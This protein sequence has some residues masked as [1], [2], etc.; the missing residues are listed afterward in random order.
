MSGPH[1][2]PPPP[3]VGEGMYRI[4]GFAGSV[5]LLPP[6]ELGEGWDGARL[7]PD[8]CVIKIAHVGGPHPIPPPPAVGEGM[9]AVPGFAGSVVLLPPAKLG[10]GWDGGRRRTLVGNDSHRLDLD[11]QLLQH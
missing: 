3:A 1:P 10:E 8:A 5:V 6:A 2:I 11:Q 9:Y 7:Y 4:P